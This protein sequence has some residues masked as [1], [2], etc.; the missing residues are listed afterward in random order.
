VTARTNIVPDCRFG[1][2]VTKRRKGK[3]PQGHALWQCECDCGATVV[4]RRDNLQTGNTQSCGCTR[5]PGPLVPMNT[6]CERLDIP[7]RTFRKWVAEDPALAV[8]RSS[9]GHRPTFWIKLDRLAERYGLT[10][11]DAYTLPGARWIRASRLATRLGISRFT[12]Q[13]WCRDRPGFARR[14]GRNFYVD[15]D[16]LGVSQERAEECLQKLGIGNLGQ[17]TPHEGEMS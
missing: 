8:L 13:N 3:D 9:G 2:L 4:I 17:V 12:M 1:S 16:A 15:L 14:L 11:V 7:T 5:I 10:Q 6:L